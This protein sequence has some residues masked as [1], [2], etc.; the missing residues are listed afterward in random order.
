[1]TNCIDTRLRMTI[2]SMSCSRLLD[3]AEHNCLLV[4]AVADG[5][6][7]E[8]GGPAWRATLHCFQLAPQCDFQRVKKACITQLVQLCVRYGRNAEDWNKLRSQLDKDTLF[9]IMQ[10]AFEEADAVR[11]DSMHDATSE[12]EE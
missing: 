12:G 10:A 6:Y 11:R 4:V 2:A 9:E 8:E 1:M 3:L 5:V 7:E